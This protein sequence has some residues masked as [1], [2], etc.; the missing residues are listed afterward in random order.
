[1]N[2]GKLNRRIAVDEQ[3]VTQ[4]D[5]GELSVTFEPF[6]TVWGSIEPLL[7]REA[8]INSVNVAQMDTRIRLR[9]TPQLDAM[10]TEWRLRYK[11]LIYD[12]VSIAHV[13]TGRRE[14]EVLCKSGTNQG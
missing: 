14:L 1:M 10:T 12:I 8:L 13:M 9:W 11:G 4:A 2:A 6:A 3:I 5:S 7:G